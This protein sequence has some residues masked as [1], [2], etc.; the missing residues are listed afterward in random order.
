MM[1]TAST[2][3][4]D[5]VNSNDTDETMPSAAAGEK[6]QT[7]GGK[8]GTKMRPNSSLTARNLCALDWC[9]THPDG[10]KAEFKHYYDHEISNELKKSYEQRSKEAKLGQN[11][12]SG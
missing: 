5:S 3:P 10:T 7:N 12:T 11:K 9:T 1:A 8:K 2:N 6:G 4:V